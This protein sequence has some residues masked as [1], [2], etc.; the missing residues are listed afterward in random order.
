M[1]S[2]KTS[3]RN[4]ALSVTAAVTVL[5][6]PA[7]ADEPRLT[8]AFI[9]GEAQSNAIDRADYEKAVRQLEDSTDSG[10]SG[11]FVANNLCVSYLKMGAAEKAQASCEQAVASIEYQLQEVQESRRTRRNEVVA[12]A[13]EKYLAIA[14]SNRG[15]TYFVNDNP[16]AARA[17]FSAAIEIRANLRQAHTNLARIKAVP[18]TSA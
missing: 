14:L 8:V 11:F 9:S 3:I 13:Y 1:I 10:L 12:A 15:V 4:V 6:G 7:L 17:D 18:A 5:A 2:R 16:D